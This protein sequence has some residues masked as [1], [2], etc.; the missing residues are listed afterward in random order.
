[1]R[2]YILKIA[3]GLSNRWY[4]LRYLNISRKDFSRDL[5]TGENPQK[6]NWPN[7]ARFSFNLNFDDYSVKSL[8]NNNY[9]YGGAVGEGVNKIFTDLLADYP[10][11]KVTLFTVP[12]ARFKN[13]AGTF[14]GR[15]GDDRY[16]LSRPEYTPLINWFKSHNTQVEVAMHGYDH[17]N[18]KTKL[19]LAPAEFEL[20]TN[21]N[22]IGSR[23]ANGWAIFHKVGLEIKGF[24]PPMWGVGHN[25]G[26]GLVKQ[27]AAEDFSYV[28][29]S[30]PLSGLNWDEKRVSN[31][32]PEY[33][34]VPATE[35]ESKLLNLPQN[36]SIS[37]PIE[38]ILET[39]DRIAEMGGLVSLMGHANAEDAWMA[40]GLG[41]R[42]MVKIG[43]VLLHLKNK[44][45]GLVWFASLAEVAEFYHSAHTK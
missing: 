11:L 2:E 37:W 7:G 17:L 8:H 33:F 29:C 25:S 5:F 6:I 35:L 15:V 39:I 13:L 31:I 19:F 44:Y 10:E 42:S 14:Y 40:D 26:F 12:N 9:D 36:V 34:I 16:S 1:M 3:Q 30:S 23:L 27:L 22:E 41:P 28:S 38:K 24:R 32:Y 4:G 18:P 43:S 20:M 21:K 45:P